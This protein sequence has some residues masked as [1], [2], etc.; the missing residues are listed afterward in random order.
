[1]KLSIAQVQS[2]INY[3]NAAIDRKLDEHVR[4]NFDYLG[5]SASK[6]TT[7]EIMVQLLTNNQ[8]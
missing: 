4:D 8:L 3:I 2:I 1:M 5:T 6:T 7:E